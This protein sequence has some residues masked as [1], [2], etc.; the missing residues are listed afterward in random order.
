MHRLTLI[1]ASQIFIFSLLYCPLFCYKR[2]CDTL[3]KT[4]RGKWM[5]NISGIRNCHGWTELIKPLFSEINCRKYKLHKLSKTWQNS[6]HTLL[7]LA[8]PMEVASVSQVCLC[9]SYHNTFEGQLCKN[10]V[11]KPPVIPFRVAHQ[12]AYSTSLCAEACH[13]YP[14]AKE[15]G[16]RKGASFE[17]VYRQN[18]TEP[19]PA[20]LAMILHCSNCTEGEC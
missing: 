18:S 13:L 16:T 6:L 10:L 19:V 11:Q 17:D 14:C 9:F 7:G 3:P 2:S 1:S 20:A 12:C 8:H 5:Q 15:E 4:M